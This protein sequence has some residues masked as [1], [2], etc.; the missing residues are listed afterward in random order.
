MVDSF[1]PAA[2]SFRVTLIPDV[3]RI[4]NPSGVSPLWLCCL[5]RLLAFLS[6][7]P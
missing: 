4:N 3:A 2:G 6:L 5:A 1:T 7:P